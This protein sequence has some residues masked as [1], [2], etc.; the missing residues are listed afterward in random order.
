MKLHPREALVKTACRDL[1]HVLAAWRARHDLTCA[2]EAVAL[3]S[4]ALSTPLAMV[5]IERELA[6]ER[7]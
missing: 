1:E 6:S 5:R 4:A 2:E 3:A 7:S